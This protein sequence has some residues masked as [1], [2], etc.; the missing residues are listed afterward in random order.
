[1]DFTHAGHSK[2]LLNTHKIKE[3]APEMQTMLSKG[4]I[5]HYMAGG[6]EP[7]AAAPS[8]AS[9]GAPA[10]AGKAVAA[11]AA[12]APGEARQ[13]AAAAAAAEGLQARD[14]D[15]QVHAKVPAATSA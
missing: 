3:S 15:L 2:V 5:A 4:T 8:T 10:A 11:A 12:A 14:V 9:S 1:V 13:P 6:D 7:A